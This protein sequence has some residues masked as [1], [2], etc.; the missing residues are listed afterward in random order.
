MCKSLN[1]KYKEQNEIHTYIHY[2]LYV[3]KYFVG[4]SEDLYS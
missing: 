2:F 1:S 3:F 4:E